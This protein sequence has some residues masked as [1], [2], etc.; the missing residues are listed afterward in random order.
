MEIFTNSA[1]ETKRLA[2]ALAKK[3]KGGEVLALYGNL[4]SGKTTFVQGFVGGLGIKDRVQSPTFVFIRFYGE[5]PKIVHVDLYRIDFM[6]EVSDLGLEELLGNKDTVCLIEWPEKIKS[7]LPKDVFE[8]KF[9]YIS[10]DIR[11]IEGNF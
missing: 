7:L 2:A 10:E 1:A 9:S 6:E 11:K 8:I 5:K 4:G 3:L